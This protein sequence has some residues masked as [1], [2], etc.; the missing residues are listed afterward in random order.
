MNT[1]KEETM[2]DTC[3]R[4]KAGHRNTYQ[5]GSTVYRCDGCGAVHGSDRGRPCQSCKADGKAPNQTRVGYRCS[6]GFKVT[7]S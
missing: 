7:K 2:T 4:R 5:N 1:K 6:C 3:S